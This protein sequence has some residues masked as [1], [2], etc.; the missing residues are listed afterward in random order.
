M[1]GVPQLQA[2]AVPRIRVVSGRN[3]PK[4]VTPHA[5]EAR[6]DSGVAENIKTVRPKVISPHGTSQKNDVNLI[7]SYSNKI[8]L[9]Q[10]ASGYFLT[11]HGESDESHHCDVIDVEYLRSC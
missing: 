11:P 8:I 4:A 9:D 6:G 7:A 10:S 3:R 2:M 1:D 5:Y